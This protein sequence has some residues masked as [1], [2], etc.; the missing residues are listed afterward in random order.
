MATK[1]VFR[2]YTESSCAN[3]IMDALRGSIYCERIEDKI[4]RGIPDIYVDGGV[5][6]ECKHE[7]MTVGG[8]GKNVITSFFTDA[9][10]K[11][12]SRWGMDTTR[13]TNLAAFLFT[14]P[15]G[16]SAFF[17][18]RFLSLYS[19]PGGPPEDKCLWTFKKARGWGVK[20]EDAAPYIRAC[21][22]DPSAVW[23]KHMNLE[24]GWSVKETT[25]RMYSSTG[26]PE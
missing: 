23:K 13:D 18:C 8:R 14:N 21:L 20:L 9:Q 12:L 7:V 2:R 6:I 4:R 10:K 11:R 19:A 3:A 25:A 22:L 26:S 5:W 24:E 1:K 16:D 15:A 17:I